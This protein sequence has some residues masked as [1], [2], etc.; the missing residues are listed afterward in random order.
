MFARL[1][2][3]PPRSLDWPNSAGRPRAT[4]GGGGIAIPGNFR[5][6]V[7]LARMGTLFMLPG[8]TI[9]VPLAAK[10]GRALGVEVFPAPVED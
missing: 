1:R 3:V 5:D 7:K 10:I 8:G 2:S 6:Y 4:G 9:T